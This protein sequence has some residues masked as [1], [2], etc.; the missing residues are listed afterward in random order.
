MINLEIAIQL[1]QPGSLAP[2]VI[3]MKEIDRIC[4]RVDRGL[5]G[6]PEKDHLSNWFTSH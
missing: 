2:R 3:G 4:G 5:P 1:L 6:E